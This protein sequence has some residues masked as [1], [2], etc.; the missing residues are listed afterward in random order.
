MGRYIEECN[1][2]QRMKN[3][4]EVSAEK[5]KLS[6]YTRKIMDISD[7]KFYYKVAISGWKICN[8]SGL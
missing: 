7:S 2:Y 1:M 6:K 4:I 3:R 8:S 5:L